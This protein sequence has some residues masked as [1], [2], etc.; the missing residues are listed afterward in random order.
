[1]NKCIDCKKVL[2]DSRNKRCQ[3]CYLKI[4]K[5]KNHPN[6]KH[7]EAC[8]NKKHFCKDCGKKVC[9]YIVIRCRSC[10]KKGKLNNLFG[11]HHTLKSR[12]KASLSKGG[13]GIPYEFNKYP[14]KF[15]KIRYWILKRDNHTCQ[16]CNKYGNEIH[17]IDYDKENNKEDNLLVLCHKCNIRANY[18]RSY[19][20]N[21]YQ[22]K[23][24]ISS[25]K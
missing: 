9:D 15:F 20:I 2:K 25:E 5:G 22:N 23:L 16:K 4:M 7:G 19:W 18:N 10:S 13:T 14:E 24:R 8:Q 1:M 3:K 21:F 6:Y 11:K 12:K 17:H